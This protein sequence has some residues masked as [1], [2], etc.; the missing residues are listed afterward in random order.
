MTDPQ[1]DDLFDA[2][3]DRL[4][5]YGQE[6]PAPLW[7]SIRAQLPP[8][9]AAPQLRQR[10]RRR[11][12]ALA[13]LL[14][15]AAS[16]GTWQW[17]QP[18]SRPAGTSATQ[19]ASTN[20]VPAANP[21]Q[22]AGTVLPEAARTTGAAAPG[23]LAASGAAAGTLGSRPTVAATP[24][25]TPAATHAAARVAAAGMVA[26]H[27]Y[28]ATGV[29]VASGPASRAT[30]SAT[31]GGPARAATEAATPSAAIAAAG[32]RATAN[33][34]LAF[35]AFA[36]PDGR[37]VA[38]VPDNRPT[39][40]QFPARTPGLPARGENPTRTTGRPAV[41]ATA[42]YPPTQTLAAGLAQAAWQPARPRVAIV[43]F[44][45]AGAPA[46]L[47]RA[48]TLPPLPVALGRRWA[49]QAL[50][51]PALTARVLGT[52]QL[53]YAPVPATTSFP[54]SSPTR[55]SNST[56]EDERATSGFGAEAQLQRQLNGRWSL[57][58]GLGYHAFATSQTV[59]VRVVYDA[60][61][62]SVSRPDS[63]GT[64]RARNTYH[65]LT[66]PLRVGYELGA[67][68]A[69]L[70]YGLRA[71][72]DVALYL[73]GRST[74]GSA[75]GGT[76]RNWGASSSPYRPLSLALSLGAEVRYRLAPGWEL[77]AQPTLTHFVTSV[78][79]PSSGYVP[80]YPLAASGLVGIAHW[81]R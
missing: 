77:L 55:L 15:V 39:A 2:L 66:L 4:A 24:A 41:S 9:V 64:L 74:E 63:V 21:G 14:L 13:L 43:V 56:T 29:P 17:R 58:T 79:R 44:Q 59:Q 12:A 68:H 62:A 47:A 10:T 53:A 5:D 36:L 80:R 73:G 8:P 69:R 26:H 38:T 81:L 32:A 23:A 1:P 78:A 30:Y 31:Y 60:P 61:T 6:P 20:P 34:T 75:Y 50:V 70:R 11:R 48:D 33:D 19:I 52:R 40:T 25:A 27:T 65:F 22:G 46:Q 67:G 7:A 72:A 3:R 57:A 16:V 51:G 76:S 18:D 45:P 35:R 37:A 54:N 71:G 49:V 28:A 42:E